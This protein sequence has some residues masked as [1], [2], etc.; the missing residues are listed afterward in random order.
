MYPKLRHDIDG[1]M[2]TARLQWLLGRIGLIGADSTPDQA[3]TLHLDLMR[4]CAA[5]AVGEEAWREVLG[6]ALGA[7]IQAEDAVFLD[8]F[9]GHYLWLGWSGKSSQQM[10]YVLLLD[11]L[12]AVESGR[13]WARGV[14][15]GRLIQQHYPAL[16]IGPYA[17][18]HCKEVEASRPGHAVSRRIVQDFERAHTLAQRAGEEAFARHI[19]LR[20]NLH[21][22]KHGVGASKARRALKALGTTEMSPAMMLWYAEGMMHS[23]FW[24]DRV[25]ALD[26]LDD[27]ARDVMD[28]RPSPAREQVHLETLKELADRLL[29]HVGPK[30]LHQT[31]EDRLVAL[32]ETLHGQGS[33]HVALAR[34]KLEQGKQL[35]SQVDVSWE[36]FKS[37]AG[38]TA[39]WVDRQFFLHTLKGLLEHKEGA[40]KRAMALVEE[41]GDLRCYEVHVLQVLVAL[42]RDDLVGF[43]GALEAINATWSVAKVDASVDVLRV[44]WPRALEGLNRWAPSK[45]DRR[46]H[47]EAPR[48]EHVS[49]DRAAAAL[50][51]A[52]V[53]WASRRLEE[54]SYGMW[55]LIRHVLGAKLVQ[56]AHLMAKPLVSQGKRPPE[57]LKGEVYGAILDWALRHGPQDDLRFWLEEMEPKR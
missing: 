41:G 43:G 56:T 42:E 4:F 9:F 26:M 24:L 8:E 20:E 13:R 18:A 15:L 31:E 17:I 36:A 44:V 48:P 6:V 37:L 22:L 57:E 12:E 19:K 1:L 34:E 2:A 35:E 32:L 39:Y 53:G 51:G 16:A 45:A 28:L 14:H 46:A 27:L 40:A 52:L 29:H 23:E 54:P 30:R 5:H 21:R 10:P 7:A 33:Q 47:L 11:L 3:A 38:H 25:R 55:P 49:W 50:G